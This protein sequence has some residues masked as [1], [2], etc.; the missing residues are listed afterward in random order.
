ML[1]R[2]YLLQVSMN[3]AVVWSDRDPRTHFLSNRQRSIKLGAGFF[4]ASL[5]Q[6]ALNFP[7]DSG[8]SLT[9]D[10]FWSTVVVYI[11]LNY[12]HNAYREPECSMIL[13]EPTM[14]LKA[15]EIV[16]TGRAGLSANWI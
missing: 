13:P 11:G 2:V 1:V 9:A 14:R 8:Y 10:Q 12:L 6:L 4:K 16:F 7:V 5:Q 3:V 15:V